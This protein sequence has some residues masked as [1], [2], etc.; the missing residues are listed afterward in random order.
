MIHF[1]TD[2]ARKMLTSRQMLY[3]TK[4]C[5]AIVVGKKKDWYFGINHMT[6]FKLKLK[7]FVTK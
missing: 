5:F 7:N 4:F 2:E 1:L 6:F 3:D